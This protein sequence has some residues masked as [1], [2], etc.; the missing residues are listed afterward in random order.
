MHIICVG[1]LI[2]IAYCL[3][4]VNIPIN[5]HNEFK[6]LISTIVTMLR[7]VIHITL[8]I[9]WCISLKNRII[10]I[11]VRR[12]LISVGFLLT[13]WLLVRICKWEFTMTVHD[14]LGRY[15]WYCYYIPMV[16][17]PLLGIFV[18]DYIGKPEYY[19][20]P[21][22][23][24][25]LYIPAIM[26]LI[27]IFTNDLHQYTFIFYN[28]IENYDNDYSYGFIYFV[29]MA[30]FVLLGIYFVVMLI[31]K[32]RV[33]GSN[34]YR[35]L[36]ILIMVSA[37]IFWVLYCLRMIK[38]DL[39]AMDC[40]IIILLLESSVQCGMI[41]SNSNYG[42]VF[43]SMTVPVLVVDK[44]YCTHYMSAKALPITKEQ[45]LKSENETINTGATLLH[46]LPIRAGRVL[47]QDDITQLNELMERLQD[48]QEQLNEENVLLKAELDLKE[49]RV[50]A[51]EK[52]RLYDRIAK[53]VEPQLIK[54]DELLKQ[55][56]KEPDNTHSLMVKVCVIGSYIKRRGNL[57]LIAEE[58]NS[59]RSKELEYCIRESLDN[60]RLGNIF[61]VLDSNCDGTFPSEY[62]IAIYDFYEKLVENLLDSITAM[63]IN[64][65]CT[66]EQLIMN[67]QL[68]CEEKIAQR[69]LSDISLA[70][71][72][73]RYT[74]QD[75]DIIVD[76][77]IPFGGVCR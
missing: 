73:Y 17:I 58:N 45:M 74:I 35:M 19:K 70:Y 59:I 50:Q 8:I 36:P 48:T 16:I 26:L 40:L 60:L 21:K 75:E 71:G 5:E 62:V 10:S 33:P 56:D 23:M 12:L 76:I 29:T 34:K 54:V 2:I 69:I 4:Y 72:T 24:N 46:N 6:S 11:P 47:W 22:W 53:E 27:G 20:K 65:S 66:N 39:T 49:R 3:R 68:G 63:M 38:C 37:V 31:K 30:W 64:L 32:S 52:N 44:E 57:L 13:F 9:S 28:G 15:L 43:D 25:Y 42:E 7:N 18:I 1:I 51:E 14:T 67:M 61:T 77:T 41:P 55:I